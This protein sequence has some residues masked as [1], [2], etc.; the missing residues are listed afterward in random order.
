MKTTVI[1][2]QITTVEDKIAGNLN[3]TQIILLLSSLFVATFIYAVLPAKLSFSIYKIVLILLQFLAFGILSLR[4]KGRVILNW[5][6][7]L[8]SY[9]FRPK[10]YV[11]NKND[12]F[13]REDIILPFE[14]KKTVRVKAF[15]KKKAKVK[16]VSLADFIKT[17]AALANIRSLSFKFDKK[18][19]VDVAVSK[20]KG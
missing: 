8:S 17:Q 14:Q 11:F 1:P 16:A 3:L 9:Y 18:G 2:A 19:G 7:L 13:Q 15:K 12:L 6:F 5:I 10:Y 4:I 20:I